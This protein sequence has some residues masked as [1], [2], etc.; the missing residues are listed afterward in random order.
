MRALRKNNQETSVYNVGKLLV[1][2]GTYANVSVIHFQE[3]NPEKCTHQNKMTLL[4][5]GGKCTN[6]LQNGQID[7]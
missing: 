3:T 1:H 4:K 5:T 7:K 2:K 6:S